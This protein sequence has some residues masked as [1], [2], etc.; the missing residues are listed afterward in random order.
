MFGV[1]LANQG[2]VTKCTSIRLYATPE[3]EIKD[4][5]ESIM[6]MLDCE[7]VTRLYKVSPALSFAFPNPPL[8]YTVLPLV[9]RST[10]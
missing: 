9:P 5:A 6:N 4:V 10:I 8:P 1:S 7:H 2:K 3:K